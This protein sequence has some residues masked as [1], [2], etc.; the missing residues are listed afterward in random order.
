MA[1][2]CETSVCETSVRDYILLMQ[3]SDHLCW[4]NRGPRDQNGRC[5][6]EYYNDLLG[7]GNPTKFVLIYKD[8][9]VFADDE[10]IKKIE[11]CV[12]KLNTRIT[13]YIKNS[14]PK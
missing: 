7:C 3:H 14:V 9:D 1:S 12:E 8:G 2:V 11:E 13:E 4:F 6:F 10:N 5:N